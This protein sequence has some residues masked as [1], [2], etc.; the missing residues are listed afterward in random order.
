M[1]SLAR[2]VGAQNAPR[3][4]VASSRGRLA[5]TG[6]FGQTV[7][8][9]VVITQPPFAERLPARL[10][11][12]RRTVRTMHANTREELVRRFLLIKVGDACNQIQRAESE[13][14][15]RAQPFLVDA[16]IRVYDDERGG[17]RLEVETRDDVS[18]LFSPVF[19]GA[20]PYLRSLQVGEGNLGGEAQRAVLRWRDG[21]GYR[22]RLGV[23]YANYLL[24]A[25]RNELRVNAQ[26][27]EFGHD[28]NVEAIRP[29]YT[30]L[31]RTAWV[32]SVGSAREPAW[33]ARRSENPRVL[34][35]D[36]E[37]AQLGGV[38][39]FGTVGRL[40]LLGLMLTRE[41]EGSDGRLLRYTDTAL[42]RDT[43]TL[44]LPF[45]TQNV[46]RANAMLGLRAIRFVR[47]QGF[48]AL[49]GAQDVRVGGQLGL[50]AGQSI[51]VASAVDRDRFVATNLYLGAGGQKWFAGL[52]GITEA[53]YDLD[54][55]RWANMIASG[56]AA[57][58][59]R[60]AV[61]QTTV[62]QTE[63]ATGRDMEAP[64]QLSLADRVGGL[65]GHRGSEATGASRLVFR[66][67]QRMVVPTRL[68]LADVG[69][70][71]FAEAGRLWSSPSV[72]FTATTPW[73]GA[74]GFSLLAALPPSS[75]R[76]WRVD[77]AMPVG[78]DPD[79]K[80]QIRF[81][82]VD[83]SRAFWQDP[84]DVQWARERT[85]PASLFNWP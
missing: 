65:L 41:K 21:V 1:Q 33:F 54:R 39:R 22:D 79:R 6:C 17:V 66:A 72:P 63:W 74:V 64:M 80:F 82:G 42:V 24:G 2:T 20:A 7:S 59:F 53:R 50:V 77:F 69:L 10:E 78:G 60:P 67:E 32:A 76:L 57:W 4:P 5:V 36:R 75:R 83:R 23:E 28:V 13:R 30:D 49:T 40:K 31:Q 47:V 73:R 19:V 68:N 85:A 26:R 9:I 18:L 71:G 16:R 48:D 46:M 37:Y 12:V 70:A 35:T 56:R 44:P 45:R 51:P 81:S 25:A 27:T 58:Y 8:D 43:T 14:I 62:M 15:L 52:Q 84:S 34:M 38:A 55:R 61:R 3:V 11:F 29:Y